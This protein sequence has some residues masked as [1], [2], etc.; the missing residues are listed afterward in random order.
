MHGQ[1]SASA[2][3]P[4]EL[5][6]VSA[7]GLWLRLDTTTH[8]LSFARYPAFRDAPIRALAN[9]EIPCPNRVYWPE[10]DVDLAIESIPASALSGP[11]D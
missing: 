4:V 7:E 5:S 1:T 3:A 10:L 6:R 8:F 9:V 11:L 2:Q